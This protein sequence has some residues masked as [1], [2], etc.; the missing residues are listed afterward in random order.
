MF[1]QMLLLVDQFDF[2]KSFNNSSN[3]NSNSNRKTHDKF[4][5]SKLKLKL[6]APFYELD[7][8][9]YTTLGTSV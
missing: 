2:L 7:L 3:L 1:D 8:S 6:E 9:S 5:D 4:L